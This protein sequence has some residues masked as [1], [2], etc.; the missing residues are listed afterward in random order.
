MAGTGN[1]TSNWWTAWGLLILVWAAFPL[2]WMVSL[3]FRSPDSFGSGPTFWP[4]EWTWE[5][6][7]TVFSDELFTWLKT[8]VFHYYNEVYLYWSMLQ[9]EQ[10]KR[11]RSIW[12]LHLEM[13][14]GQLQA[15][16]DLLR[17]YEGIEPEELLP[18]SLPDTPVTFEPN[19][20]YVREILASQVDLRTDGVDYV[21]DS[22]LPADHRSRQ[23]R[24]RINFGGVPS[25]LKIS[26]TS[27]L[28][29][30]LRA[31]STVFGGEYA[32]S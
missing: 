14:L 13:E 16:C 24:E 30:S 21:L 4:K 12:E 7:S 15:A 6:F 11:I 5:N 29:T 23:Y 1:R 28:S 31:C 22:D 18:P 17:R 26:R 25:E 27:S 20:D 2:L 8:L 9:N 19:K 3:A 10:D 32:S